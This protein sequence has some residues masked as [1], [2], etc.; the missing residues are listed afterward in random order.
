MQHITRI[1]IEELPNDIFTMIG[2]DWMLVSAQHEGVANT[3]T[4]SWG[5]M[6]VLWNKKVAFVFIRPQRYTKTFID[7][8]TMFSLT[9]YNESYRKELSYFG[10]V[11]GRDEDKIK[12]ANFHLAHV[13]NTPYFKEANTILI[14]HKLYAQDMVPT[15]FLQNEL[16][17]RNYPNNDFHTMY[18][19]EIEAVYQKK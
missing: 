6:G 14:C 2:K 17:T 4:A 13:D 9:F 10:H 12:K 19:A 11:S 1:P 3:M 18:I 15:S 7:T 8:T 5:G 16:I